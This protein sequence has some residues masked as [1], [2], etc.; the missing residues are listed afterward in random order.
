[1]ARRVIRRLRRRKGVTVRHKRAMAGG[2]VERPD[3][4]WSSMPWNGARVRI[5]D[6]PAFRARWGL[7]VVGGDPDLEGEP[8]RPKVYVVVV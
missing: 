3:L 7:K 5:E 2:E 4:P 8:W 6:L 1:M